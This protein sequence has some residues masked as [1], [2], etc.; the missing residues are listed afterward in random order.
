MAR[1]KHRDN[2]AHGSSARVLGRTAATAPDRGHDY[3][4]ARDRAGHIRVGLGLRLARDF[5]VRKLLPLSVVCHHSLL[6]VA[7]QFVT[8]PDLTV[9]LIVR[10]RGLLRAAPFHSASCACNWSLTL[11]LMFGARFGV[12]R[13]WKISFSPD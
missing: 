9:L 6:G 7:T 12:R 3:R 8:A 5:A 1:R 13:E 11:A 4:G 2:K 10:P